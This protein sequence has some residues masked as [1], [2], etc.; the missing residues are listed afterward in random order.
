MKIT[1]SYPSHHQ[2][3][4]PFHSAPVLFSSV[5]WSTLHVKCT[6]TN[7]Q[8]CYITAYSFKIKM[9]SLSK[10]NNNN[11]YYYCY[12]YCC[13]V[14]IIVVVVIIIVVV[15]IVIIIIII[16][17]NIVIIIII[18]I[19]ILCGRAFAHFTI[20]RRIDPHGGTT[21]LFLVPAVATWTGVT[22]SVVCALLSVI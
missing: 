9:I 5:C 18:I 11:Y 4:D 1:Y 12:Y 22:K 7:K 8:A 13:V 16:I 6:N 17:I 2:T 21:E 3:N 19:I 20:G 15:I 10:N 14:V